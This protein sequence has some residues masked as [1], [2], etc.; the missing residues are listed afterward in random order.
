MSTVGLPL[1]S[2]NI[3][4]SRSMPGH[5]AP[6][7]SPDGNE[8][9]VNWIGERLRI[10]TDGSDSKEIM[11]NDYRARQHE[12]SPDGSRIAYATN[13]FNPDENQGIKDYEIEVSNINGS[14]RKRLTRNSEDDI[15]P[16]WSPDGSRIAYVWTGSGNQEGIAVISPEGEFQKTILHNGTSGWPGRD[17]PMAKRTFRDTKPEWSPDSG[18]IAFVTR[19]RDLGGGP[20]RQTLYTIQADGTGLTKLFQT[21]GDPNQG[22]GENISWTPNG[23]E[24]SL[25]HYSEA[26]GYQLVSASRDGSKTRILAYL[27]QD[28]MGPLGEER[29]GS[30]SWSPD[31]KAVLVTIFHQIQDHRGTLQ[32]TEWGTM[33]VVNI[34]DPEEAW[35]KPATH[36]AWSPD[37]SQIAAVDPRKERSV[38]TV[39]AKGENMQ[40]VANPR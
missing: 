37:G 3:Q 23:T 20:E 15:H 40:P 8:I 30:L 21:S 34:E 27:P 17:E 32:S 4:E 26:E 36:A 14:G 5:S 18:S 2:A 35:N 22:I 29:T 1:C 28:A 11:K 6:Q 31:G 38:Y 25:L 33:F 7:W 12:P 39:S 16:S 9:T 24:V 13:R 10:R 19:W